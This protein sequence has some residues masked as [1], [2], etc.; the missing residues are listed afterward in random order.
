[1]IGVA[2]YLGYNVRGGPVDVGVATARSMAISLVAV[3]VVNLVWVLMFL[4]KP[5][6]P[7][8]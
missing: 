1:V 3:T 5:Q 8:A 2:L 7:I 4:I 6:I